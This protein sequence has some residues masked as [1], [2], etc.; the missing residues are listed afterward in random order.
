MVRFGRRLRKSGASSGGTKGERPG[1]R[2]DPRLGHRPPDP[3]GGAAAV[4]ALGYPARA[5]SI[6]SNASAGYLYEF[7]V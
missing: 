5:R 6:V 4:P 1:G 2:G 7:S 3:A